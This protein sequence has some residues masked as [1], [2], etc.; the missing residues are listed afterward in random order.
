MSGQG[1]AI[2]CGLWAALLLLAIRLERA[3]RRLRRQEWWGWIMASLVGLSATY[4]NRRRST[5]KAQTPE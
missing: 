4:E 5:E 2:V 1:A 3:A